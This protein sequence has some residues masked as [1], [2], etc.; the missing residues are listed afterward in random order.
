M[1]YWIIVASKDHLQRGIAGGFIQ[2]NHGKAASL[3]RMQAGDWVL[4]YSPKLEFEKPEKL[5]CFTAICRITDDEIYQHDMGGG[6][7]PFRRNVT[8]VPAQ[9]VSILPL[10]QKLTFIKDKT[11]WGAPFRFG[12]LEIP[13]A[14]FHLI[15]S[16][17]VEDQSLLK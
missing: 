8:F 13:K 17:M 5:Q 9:D 3:K 15:A 12:T 14:D 6:F 7:V 10:I 11:H 4:F 2:A 16:K 1:K